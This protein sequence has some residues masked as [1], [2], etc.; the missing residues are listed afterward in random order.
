MNG[1]PPTWDDIRRLIERADQVCR[2]SERLRAQAERARQRPQFYPDR[3]QPSR[4]LDT[5]DVDSRRENEGSDSE[6]TDGTL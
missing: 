6:G 5:A 2:E 3:R 4:V 1:K